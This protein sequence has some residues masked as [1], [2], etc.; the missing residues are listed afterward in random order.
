MRRRA[1][2]GLIGSTRQAVTSRGVTAIADKLEAS[3]GDRRENETARQIESPGKEMAKQSNEGGMAD[4]C[5]DICCICLEGFFRGRASTVTNCNHLYHLQC[6]LEW[7]QRSSNCPTCRQQVIL[8][9]PD[10]RDLLEAIEHEKKTKAESL[11]NAASQITPGELESPSTRAA[12]AQ[13]QEQLRQYMI[14]MGRRYQFSPN[15]ASLS[16]TFFPLNSSNSNG[17]SS[18]GDDVSLESLTAQFSSISNSWNEAMFLSVLALEDN[19]NTASGGVLVKSKGWEINKDT[20]N[21]VSKEYQQR[22]MK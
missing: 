13:V 4:A 17:E 18:A 10:S 11:R 16:F 9:E 5:D 12:E 1:I 7:C 6:I 15:E 14:N 20:D 2:I 21:S 8:K 19:G 3:H 22:E